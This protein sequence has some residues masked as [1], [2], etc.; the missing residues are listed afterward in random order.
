MLLRLRPVVHGPHHVGPECASHPDEVE[1]AFIERGR[2]RGLI[3]GAALV[4][5]AGECVVIPAGEQHR[6][7]TLAEGCAFVNVRLDAAALRA[8]AVDMGLRGLEWRPA[9]VPATGGLRAALEGL[10]AEREDAAPGQALL[11]DSLTLGLAVRLLRALGGD[12]RGPKMGSQLRLRRAEEWMRSDLGAPRSIAEL[13]DLAE[14]SPFHFARSFKQA[15]GKSP[16][17]YL[18]GLRLERATHLIETTDRALTDLAHELGFSSSSRFSEAFRRA[19][20]LP[21]STLRR[22]RP[23]LS[24]SER[25]RSG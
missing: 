16:H 9:V 11:V 18:L 19:Y 12:R 1:L 17:A 7:R 14:M 6:T 22:Q 10:R 23:Q 3:G 8:L 4:G 5:H 20:G 2:E 21:P 15:Y 24:G 13:A 25:A